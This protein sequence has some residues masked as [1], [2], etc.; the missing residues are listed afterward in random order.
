[1]KSVEEDRNVLQSKEA[2]MAK[3]RGTYEELKARREAVEQAVESAQQHFQAVN[4][5]LSSGAGGQEETLAAQKI[6]MV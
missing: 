4:A 6:G 2:E 1:M 3:G 5:G